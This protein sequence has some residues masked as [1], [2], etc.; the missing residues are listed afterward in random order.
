MDYKKGLYALEKVKAG[1]T[2]TDAERVAL[3]K[4][5]D[6]DEVKFSTCLASQAYAKQVESDISL[7]ET[8]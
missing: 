2:V 7:G 8:K 1:K 3:A 6:L 4:T 5:T